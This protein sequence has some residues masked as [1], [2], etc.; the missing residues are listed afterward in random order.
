MPSLWFFPFSL[1]CNFLILSC[2]ILIVHIDSVLDQKNPVTAP[3]V[4]RDVSR[5][6]LVLHELGIIKPSVIV[7]IP[8]Q[9]ALAFSKK[10][11]VFD[12]IGVWKTLHLQ[13]YIEQC[14]A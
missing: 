8:H 5:M 14:T 12:R 2:P 11:P 4:A 7:L 9:T 1:A 3:C 13:L 6:P 10:E